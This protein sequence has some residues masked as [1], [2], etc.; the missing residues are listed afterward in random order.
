MYRTITWTLRSTKTRNKIQRRI[1]KHLSWKRVH[2]QTSFD[3]EKNTDHAVTHSVFKSNNYI[4][5]LQAQFVKTQKYV[6]SFTFQLLYSWGKRP[7][8]QYCLDRSLNGLHRLSWYDGKEKKIPASAGNWTCHSQSLYWLSY[9]S[10]HF[11]DE[12]AP[13]LVWTWWQWEK[14]LPYW[15]FKA[16]CPDSNKS[17]KWQLFRLSFIM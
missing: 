15:K 16:S 13:E 8:P 12:W 7:H 5:D 17:L 4:Y 9:I 2:L 10:S 1:F 3:E 11:E 14:F 6:V